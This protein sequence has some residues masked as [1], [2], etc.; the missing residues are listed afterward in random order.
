ML[1]RVRIGVLPAILAIALAVPGAGASTRSDGPPACAPEEHVEALRIQ[2]KRIE[3]LGGQ[4]TPDGRAIADGAPLPS[5]G[6]D[7]YA[8]AQVLLATNVPPA[9]RRSAC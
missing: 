2:L 3:Q 7:E 4:L 6:G 1:P 9:A 8:T 5:A